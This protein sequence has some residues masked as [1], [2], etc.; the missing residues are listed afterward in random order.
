M[1][2]N[3]TLLQPSSFRL[4]SL[5]V[6][7]EGKVLRNESDFNQLVE[8][9]KSALLVLHFLA[10]WAPQCAQVTDVLKE[11]SKDK[12][13]GNVKFLEVCTASRLQCL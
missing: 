10:D 1:M 6:M 4:K 11:L 7:S 3:N 13:V 5:F 9:N 2:R 8:T 12:S